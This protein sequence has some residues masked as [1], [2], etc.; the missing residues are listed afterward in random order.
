MLT[1]GSVRG[2]FLRTQPPRADV[3][4]PAANTMSASAEHDGGHRAGSGARWPR[5]SAAL[6]DRWDVGAELWG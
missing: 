1:A 3:R 5:A 6:A 4:T 2:S